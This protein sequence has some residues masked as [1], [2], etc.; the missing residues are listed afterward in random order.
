M[1]SH[2]YGSDGAQRLREST[3]KFA[4]RVKDRSGKIARP[5]DAEASVPRLI[6]TSAV[7]ICRSAFAFGSARQSQVQYLQDA[8]MEACVGTEWL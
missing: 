4:I 3:V 6:A 2:V 8:Y 5:G 1:F 7:T